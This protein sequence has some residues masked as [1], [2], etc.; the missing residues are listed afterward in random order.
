M[1]PCEIIYNIGAKQKKYGDLS[2][3][4]R[5][6]GKESLGMNFNDWV[7]DTFTDHGSLK[8]GTIISNEALFCFDEASEI[9]QAKTGKDKLQRF[10]TYSHVVL[11]EQ[12]FC[13]TKAHKKEIFEAIK[14]GAEIVCLTDSGQKHVLF[15]HKIGFWQLDELFVKPDLEFFLSLHSAMTDLMKI[16]FNQSSIIEGNYNPNFI[17]KNGFEIWREKETYLKQH[18]GSGMFGFASWMLFLDESDKEKVKEQMSKKEPKKEQKETIVVQTE[19]KPQLS[20]F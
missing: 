5:I 11:N 16:G 8:V 14:K 1:S 13:F 19:V 4:C 9:I 20:L 12:W 18:R 3:I 6:T 7:K 15:K 2:G 10:R 17:Q